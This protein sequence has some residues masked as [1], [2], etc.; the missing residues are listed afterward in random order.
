MAALAQWASEENAVAPG[1][2]RRISELS[3]Q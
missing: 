3:G 1:L 2:K